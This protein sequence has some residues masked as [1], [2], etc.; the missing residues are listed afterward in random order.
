MY[1]NKMFNKFF[2]TVFANDLDAF[3]PEVW[4]AESLMI[5]HANIVAA[6]LVHT[7]FKDEIAQA[8]DLVNTRRPAKFKSK[9]KVDTDDVTTQNATAENVP[10]KLDQHHHV[11]FVIKDGEE[12]KGMQSLVDTYLTPALQAVAQG[13]EEAVIGEKYNFIDNI[14]GQLG[15]TPTKTTVIDTG[16]KLTENKAPLGGRNL[17]ISPATE[18]DLLNIADF[19][20]A[21]KVGDDGTALRE[22]SLGRK[23]GFQIH[24]A[25]NCRSI[26]VA[27]GGKLTAAV[28]FSSGYAAGST[29]LV[30]DG[31]TG[32]F[33]VGAWVTIAGDMT[34]LMIIATNGSTT[35]TVHTGLKTA[36]LDNAVITYYKPAIVNLGAGYAAGYSKSLTIDGI[37]VAPAIGQLASTGVTANTMKLYSVIDSLDESGNASPSTTNVVLNR[38]L[39]SAVADD[40]VVG[41]GPQGEYNWAFHRNAVALVTRPLATPSEGVGA[42]AAVLEMEGIGL[43]VVITYDGK[44]QG[45]RVT[46][47]VLA[48]VKT[49]DEN[50]GALMLG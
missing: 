22:G 20:N 3:I 11:S 10:V 40:D 26:S 21:E 38:P 28:N 6:K 48:G 33:V 8:G 49:L 45:H 35:M 31:A 34:P 18:G 27:S 24:M 15:V 25:H 19:V 12:S 17:I 36:V 14:V 5:L 46:V 39:D 43:R 42:K 47:D 29:A 7:D 16:T 41:L 1:Q 32:T 2:R 9:R 13:I 30:I 50:L 23:F 44:A 4:A 37:T